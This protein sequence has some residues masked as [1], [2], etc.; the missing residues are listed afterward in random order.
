M[1]G[2]SGRYDLSS[3]LGA[4]GDPAVSWAE[5][6]DF[7]GERSVFSERWRSVMVNFPPVAGIRETSPRAVENVERSSCAYCDGEM[8][9]KKLRKIDGYRNYDAQSP[10]NLS[11]ISDG[12]SKLYEHSEPTYAALKFH[13]HCTQNLIATRG[14]GT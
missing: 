9:C 6:D 8:D 13:L 3:K 2:G 5:I 1:M 12:G 10:K 7:G 14:S 4:L 11:L